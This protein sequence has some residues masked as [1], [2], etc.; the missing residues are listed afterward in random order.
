[1]VLRPPAI[2][3]CTAA[4]WSAVNARTASVMKSAQ[5]RL[6]SGVRMSAIGLPSASRS[7]WIL[8]YTVEGDLGQRVVVANALEPSTICGKQ[9]EACA[10][11]AFCSGDQV[12][13][14]GHKGLLR[15]TASAW[16]VSVTT[17]ATAR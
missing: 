11:C 7:T 1:M 16:S 13:L 6:S 2:E 14:G 15:R 17:C 3:T 10:F 12:D 8:L 9:R 5:R 4:C